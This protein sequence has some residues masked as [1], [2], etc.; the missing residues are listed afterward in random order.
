M[1]ARAN[2]M[3]NSFVC[4]RDE[5]AMFN[6]IGGLSAVRKTTAAFTSDLQPALPSSQKVALVCALPMKVGTAGVGIFKFGDDLYNEQQLCTGYSNKFGIASLGIKLNYVQYHAEGFG[7]KGVFTL[8]AGGIAQLTERL[9]VGAHI[10]NINQPEIVSLEHEHLPT[11][12]NVGIGFAA[13]EKLFVTT[14]IQKDLDYKAT[15][16]GGLEYKAHKKVLIRTGFNV[17]PAAGFFGVGFKP[18]KFTL[19]YAFRY[20]PATG[21]GHQASLAYTF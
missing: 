8:S 20:L 1:S 16:K 4:I 10:T 18:K 14:E 6:N 5:W 3:G 21:G 19:D 7:T 13:S 12:L 2:G 11:L 9:S 17:Y 15:W